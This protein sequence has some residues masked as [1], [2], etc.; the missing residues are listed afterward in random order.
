MMIENGHHM[1]DVQYNTLSDN[2]TDELLPTTDSYNHNSGE[3]MN[4]F[5]NFLTENEHWL[6]ERILQ[7]AKRQDYTKYTSTLL[8]AWRMS[9]S[10]L[11]NALCLAI[12]MRGDSKPQF[13]PDED[14]ASDSITEFGR[15]EAK[16]HRERGISLNMFLGLLKYYRDSYIDLITEKGPEENRDY[17][18]RF[19]IR[20]FDR[21]E[22]ALC[23]EWTGK[24]MP[25]HTEEL[26]ETTRR[27]ANEKNKYL[28][29]FESNPRPCFLVDKDGII[30]NMN[31]AATQFLGMGNTSGEMY[32]SGG[33]NTTNI[34]A[35][36][37]GK[38][39][40]NYLPWLEKE[41][42][43]FTQ[44]THEIQRVEIET[45]IINERRYFDVL[46][47][48]MLDVS[49]KFSGMLVILDDITNRKLME[50]KL[51]R[52]ATTDALTGANN[53]HRFLE[54][55]EE[56]VARTKRYNRPLSVIMLD[57]DHFKRINDTYGHAAGDDVLRL[58]SENCRQV[59][60][61]TD[62]FG[63]IGG[64]E[65][66][67]VLPETTLQ[68][69]EQVAERLRSTLQRLQLTGPDGLIRFTVSI[70]V[71]EYK[72]GQQLEHILYY[73]DQ[74]LYK[75]KRLG[76]NRVVVEVQQDLSQ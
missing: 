40:K 7:Y 64:E 34:N 11:T 25:E 69:A 67:A 30:D 43:A 20:S 60:R 71:A 16:R 45:T 37:T 75:A 66:A 39:L 57:I 33:N 48:R 9:I 76:R 10:G 58:L 70:G 74:A 55:G 14:Y 56:E 21:I 19:I 4:H 36:E 17:W 42:S 1:V 46:F 6:M 72:E 8:D 27:L 26:E 59:F 44:G 24:S 47:S 53:R 41:T 35:S 29:V 52:L 12:S 23:M 54:R 22:I 38:L 3:M 73:A 13:H 62:V 65:F 18:I 50:E 32:Y 68:Q 31:Y 15:M 49:G 51:N 28:T 5:C 61:K 2:Y 63:R